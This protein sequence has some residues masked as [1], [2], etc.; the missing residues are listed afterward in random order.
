MMALLKSSLPGS[1]PFLLIAFLAGLALATGQRTRRWGYRWLWSLF[2]LYLSFSIP[3]VSRLLA[4][5]LNWGFEPVQTIETARRFQVIV[6]LDSSTHRYHSSGGLLL[7]SPDKLSAY[8]ALEAVR[9]YR[10][11]GEPLIIVSGGNPAWKSDWAP[12][13]SALRDTL[14]KLEVPSE[15]IILDSDSHNT[16]AHTIN[17]GHLLRARGVTDFI[18]VT[19]PTH[20]R[21]S[22][23]AF[24]KEGFDP[25]PSPSAGPLDHM[26]GWGA[27]WPSLKA[28][29]QTE[30]VMHEYFG[31][32]YYRF[33]GWT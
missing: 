10:L 27:F 11:I 9:I 2:L 6:V 3:A 7:E 17:L 33:M 26:Q 22:I 24:R 13:A 25:I 20:M 4:A 32:V 30:E 29:S 21:R 5:P 31:L 28:L 23:A 14:I 18:L 15:R 16:R 19:S 12:E 8:R 1:I